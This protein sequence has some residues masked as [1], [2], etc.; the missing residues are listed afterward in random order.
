MDFV[1][2]NLS[3]M[4][5]QVKEGDAVTISATVNNRGSSQSDYSMVFRIN[6]VVEKV[7]ELSLGPGASQTAAITVNK[8]TPGEYYVDVDGSRGAF[9]VMER[10]PASFTISKLTISPEKVKQGQPIAIGFII[11][12]E[13]EKQGI[14]NASVSIKGISE[15]TEDITLE[16][17]ETKHVTFNIIKDTA[18]FYP[19]AVEHLSGRFVVEMDWKD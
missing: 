2:S 6:H 8:E 3:I 10:A 16:P 17:G 11:S 14:Y 5:M 15:A 19:V 7:T 18:G 12:N 4:P 9:M 1:V 13:G